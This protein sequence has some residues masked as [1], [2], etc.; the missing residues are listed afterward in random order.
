MRK[1]L[2][3]LILASFS[4][5]IMGQTLD[6][7]LKIADNIST[8]KYA[9]EISSISGI[10]SFD[11]SGY[12]GMTFSSSLTLFNSANATGVVSLQIFKNLG[13]G[14][15]LSKNGLTLLATF[16][17]YL[18]QS[19]ADQF[20][21]NYLS[22]HVKLKM[23]VINLFFDAMNVSR[24]I[25]YMSKDATDLKTQTDI[26]LLKNQYIYDVGMIETLL[27]VKIQ[28]LDFP[29]LNVPSNLP[30]SYTSYQQFTVRPQNS[31][32]VFGSEVNL[33]KNPSISLSFSYSWN[34]NVTQPQLNMLDVQKQKYF[35]DIQ[36]L[37]RAVKIYD[38]KLSNLLD[39]YS[40]T[41]GN[42]LQG[43]STA[44]DVKRISDEIS[45]TGY[46]RDL[47]CIELLKEYYLYE[48]ITE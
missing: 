38:S 32:L 14:F 34:Q 16:E 15:G 6:D 19:N 25:N 35:N 28:K 11:V 45:N 30:S 3:I 5:T 26:A 48:A 20:L 12:G 9:N 22:D 39:T 42:Y 43:K 10:T 4:L 24:T 31:D 13:V 17:P 8:L 44:T 21:A 33:F 7:L 1:I 27:S 23:D 2:I 29:P 41:Y 36:I 18:Y 46:E 37:S 40:T 47:F